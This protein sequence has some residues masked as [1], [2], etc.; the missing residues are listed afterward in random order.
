MAKGSQ[1]RGAWRD[2]GGALI[3]LTTLVGGYWAAAAIDLEWVFWGLA[4][5]AAAYAGARW[6]LPRGLKRLNQFRILI[7]QGQDYPR[8]LEVA[9]RRQAEVE[10]L[11]VA[12]SRAN[13]DAESQIAAG[14]LEGRRRVVGEMRAMAAGRSLTPIAVGLENGK[15]LI[16]AEVDVGPIPLDSLWCLQVKGMGT[17][18][19]ILRVVDTPSSDKALL[20]PDHARDAKFV[21]A[22]AES[23]ATSSDFPVSLEIAPRRATCI[24]DFEKEA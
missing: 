15:L 21:A 13:S 23:A 12:A 8:L 16:A 14:V 19:A 4:I 1:W 5:L 17:V 2:F 11:E 20:A 3:T 18:K 6:V 9:A 7:Q 10:E 24:E 22:L